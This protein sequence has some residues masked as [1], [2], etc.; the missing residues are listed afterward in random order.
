MTLIQ[1]TKCSFI[2][3]HQV[4]NPQVWTHKDKNDSN[5]MNTAG[6]VEM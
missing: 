5:R 3:E 1:R 6:A 2:Q 4:C